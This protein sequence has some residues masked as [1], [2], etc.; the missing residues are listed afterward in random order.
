MG[1]AGNASAAPRTRLI[2]LIPP[3]HPSACPYTSATT[4]TLT[5]TPTQLQPQPNSQPPQKHN[6]ALIELLL[7]ANADAS[8][9]NKWGA[10]ALDN[11]IAVDN[12]QQGSQAVALLRAA[13]KGQ[14]GGGG[15]SGA[16]SSADGAARGWGEG[17]GS[18]DGVPKGEREKAAKKRR[19]A[20]KR[21]AAAAKAR[22]AQEEEKAQH[23][24]LRRKRAELEMRLKEM[25]EALEG[26]M[27][28][29]APPPDAR[30]RV[31]GERP[32]IDRSRSP[33]KASAT[34]A[35]KAA[36]GEAETLGG[37]NPTVLGQAKNRLQQ[38]AEV[39]EVHKRR[40]ADRGRSPTKK[41]K[42]KAPGEKS[43]AEDLA[44]L[45]RKLV[46]AKARR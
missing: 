11:A 16:G 23:Q 13:T 26:V 10:T 45:E 18:A 9:A 40:E 2:R 24:A 5:P 27:S 6:G 32:V 8:I 44:K 4:P 22:E 20:N 29:V 1:C 46:R 17:P 39:R 19:E 33:P 42:P 21:R 36:L 3:H 37:C 28:M 15:A 43:A 41:A 25:T 35:L 14:K 12:K 34:Q 31:I 38:A 30:S 7:A